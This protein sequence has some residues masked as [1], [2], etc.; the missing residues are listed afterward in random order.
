MSTVRIS[1]TSNR[2]LV[3]A[4]DRADVDVDGRARVTESGAR[5]TIDKVRSRL[6][7]RVPHGTDVVVGSSSA[8]V[9]VRGPVGDVAVTSAS[10]R[11]SVEQ[12]GAVDVRSSSGRIEIGHAEGECRLRAKS[13]RVQVESCGG[14][15]AATT[16]G[17]IVLRGVGGPVRAH[18]VSGRIEV[19]LDGAHDVDAETVSGRIRV[20]LPPGVR[21]DG[22]DC[23]CTTRSISGRVEVT[24]R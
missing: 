24:N 17:R 3:L 16:S 1:T 21:G 14:A 8:R 5:T 22:S 15:D 23:T 18:C 20:S 7:V 12:A 19:D 11:V 2:V 10:G 6:L 4:E 9:E 13:G